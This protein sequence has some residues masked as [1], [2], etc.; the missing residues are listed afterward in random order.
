[1]RLFLYRYDPSVG[2]KRWSDAG[3]PG[4]VTDGGLSARRVAGR[5]ILLSRVAGEICAFDGECPHRGAPLERGR[6]EDGVIHCSMHGY[7]FDIRSGKGVG[8][9]H[10]LETLKVVVAEEPP[11]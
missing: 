2:R 10:Q 3:D 4:E 5:T 6:L 7:A 11:A 8:N 9:D 1:M